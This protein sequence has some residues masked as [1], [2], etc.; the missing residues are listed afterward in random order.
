MHDVKTQ[1]IRNRGQSN[2]ENR[3]NEMQFNFQKEQQRFRRDHR[4]G[5][6]SIP[7]RQDR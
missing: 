3:M 7:D 5:I 2:I 6:N 1:D 4:K